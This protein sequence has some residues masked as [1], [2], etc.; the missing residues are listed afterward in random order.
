MTIRLFIGIELPEKIKNRLEHQL[1]ALQV[2]PKGWV[3][4]H[5]YHI[6]LLFI[7]AAELESVPAILNKLREISFTPFEIELTGIHFFGRRIMY[8]KCTPSLGLTQLKEKIDAKFPEFVSN[9]NK[10]FVPH[11]TIK[12]WQRYEYDELEEKIMEN[13]FKAITF[14]VKSLALFK[15][16]KDSDLRKYHVVGR[17]N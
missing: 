10:P 15:S 7:G 1:L 4:P 14:E 2:T 6:T 12:R 17:N 16:E 13:P 9:E 3:M 5:D 11:I 8:V